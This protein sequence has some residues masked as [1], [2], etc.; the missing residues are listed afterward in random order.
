MKNEDKL[1]KIDSVTELVQISKS[2]IYEMMKIG[3]FP[4]NHGIG[5]N[6]LWF[7]SE[8]QNFI[9]NEKIQYLNNKKTA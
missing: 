3:N 2:K 9:E 6:K 5:G 7:Y 4:Q 1:L 8:I